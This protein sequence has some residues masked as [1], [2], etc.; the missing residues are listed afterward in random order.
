MLN[1]IVVL[2]AGLLGGYQSTTVQGPLASFSV[3]VEATPTGWSARCDSG[4]TWKELAFECPTACDALMDSNG[5]V[6]AA[7]LPQRTASFTFF[8]TRTRTGFAAHARRGTTWSRL[9]WSCAPLNSCRVS[10]DA[11]GV[12]GVK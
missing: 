7:T 8:L 10:I 2:V 4:C 1:S 5:L 12:C 3:S 11:Q 9:G 6:T